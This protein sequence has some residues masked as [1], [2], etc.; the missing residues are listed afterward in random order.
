VDSDPGSL[1]N[2][3]PDPGSLQ[4]MD[5]DPDVVGE[6]KKTWIRI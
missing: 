2:V 6:G 5:P 3:D 4:N 1:Q